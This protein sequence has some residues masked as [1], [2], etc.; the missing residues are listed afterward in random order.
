MQKSSEKCRLM[1]TGQ[2]MNLSYG[3]N[4]QRDDAIAVAIPSFTCSNAC[5]QQCL[6][7]ST[8]K[9]IDLRYGNMH[10]QATIFR[11]ECYGQAAMILY[12]LQS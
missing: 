7:S 6:L 8:F 1:I 4:T 3:V 9:Q 10:I 12:S 5:L 2:K 11:A